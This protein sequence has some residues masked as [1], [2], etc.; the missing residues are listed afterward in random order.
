MA[1][2]VARAVAAVAAATA[3]AAV[4]AQR[5]PPVPPSQGAVIS[6]VWRNMFVEAGYSAADVDAKINA[7]FTQLFYGDPT[8]Q[9]IYWE[10]PAEDTAYVSD[11]KNHDVR[12]EGMGYAMMVFVQMPGDYRQQFDRVWGWVQK[13][14]YHSSYDD[15]LYGWSAWHCKTNGQIIDGGPAPDGETFMVTA[16]YFAAARWGDGGKYNYTDA[17]NAVLWAVQSKEDPPCGP[18]GCNGAVNMFDPQYKVSDCCRCCCE[19][20]SMQPPVRRP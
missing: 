5:A 20:G 17:A 1:P 9:S 3:L 16:L 14:M 13:H 8:F 15:P 12:T 2:L 19:S 6:G 10:V 18:H 11:V 4:H 7:T